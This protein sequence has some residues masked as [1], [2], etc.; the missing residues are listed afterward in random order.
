MRKT[1]RKPDGCRAHYCILP[2]HLYLISPPFWLC[3]F[4]RFP[5]L[6]ILNILSDWS[7]TESR[8]L[9]FFFCRSLNHIS[10][11]LEVYRQSPWELAGLGSFRLPDTSGPSSGPLRGVKRTGNYLALSHQRTAWWE[12]LPLFSVSGLSNAMVMLFPIYA[13]AECFV[14]M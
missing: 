10:E 8:E 1:S 14:L 5:A 4:R 12:F 9:I 3:A 6:P 7:V 2:L 11:L 13:L